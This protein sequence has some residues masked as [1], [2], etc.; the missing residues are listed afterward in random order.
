VGVGG[1]YYGICAIESV[2]GIIVSDSEFD[3]LHI[4]SFSASPPGVGFRI[5]L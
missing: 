4:M 3:T 5:V 1:N 2:I